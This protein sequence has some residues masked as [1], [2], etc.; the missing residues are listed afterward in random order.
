MEQGRCQRINEYLF[1]Y[2]EDGLWNTF[3]N[4]DSQV[5]IFVSKIDN[6][7]VWKK[8]SIITIIHHK[9]V[10]EDSLGYLHMGML[11]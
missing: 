1:A 8:L 2:I 3:F 10:F 7:T 11:A 9:F 6:L 5:E 4:V